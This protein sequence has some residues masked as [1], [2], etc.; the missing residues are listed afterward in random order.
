MVPLSGHLLGCLRVDAHREDNP[1][2][3]GSTRSL[4]WF[5]CDLQ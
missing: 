4:Q 5:L 1:G 2:E 3:E